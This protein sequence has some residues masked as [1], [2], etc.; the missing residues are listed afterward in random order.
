M[1]GAVDYSLFNPNVVVCQSKAFK[2]LFTKMRDV[3]TSSKNFVKYSKRAMTLLAEE[4]LAE[5]PSKDIEIQTPCGPCSGCESIDMANAC[6]VSIVR[7][8]DALLESLRLLLPEISV[9]KI[10]IQRDESHPEK[11]PKLFYSKIP[12]GKKYIVLCDPMLATGGSA[13]MAIDCLIT[14]YQIDSSNIIF[15]NMICCPEGLQALHRSY[16]QVKIVTAV[17]DSHLNEHKFIV[18]GLG[19]YGDRFFGTTE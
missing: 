16:P 5:L 18:P 19:D 9:G 6:A 7:S 17:V 4:A 10:L 13:I 12:K 1:A 2:V 11:L 15:A 3:N 14:R 8:G